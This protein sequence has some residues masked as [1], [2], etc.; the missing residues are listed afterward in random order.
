MQ[1][2][3]IWLKPQPK[4]IDENF[5]DFLLYLRNADNKSEALYTESLRL[6]QQRVDLLIDERQKEPIFR[7]SKDIDTLHFNARLC[8]AWLLCLPNEDY[9]KRK[10]VTIL[11]L[12][13]LLHLCLQSETEEDDQFITPLAQMATSLL[14]Y[15]LPD[16]PL[17][18][19]ND[20]TERNYIATLHILTQRQFTTQEEHFFEHKGTF[21]S[22]K[23][24][25]AISALGRRQF[26]LQNY[27]LRQS[28]LVEDCRIDVYTPREKNIREI[29][30]DNINAVEKTVEYLLDEISRTEVQ[31]YEVPRRHYNDNDEV[32][33][34]VVSITDNN[35]ILRTIDP[36]YVPVEG[37]LMVESNIRLY[38]T[39][40]PL[41]YWRSHLHVGDL[42]AVKV[43]V[44]GRCFS[45]TKVL[46]EYLEGGMQLGDR[47]EATTY[48]IEGKRDYLE[49]WTETGEA[50]FVHNL[51]NADLEKLWHNEGNAVIEITS[52]GYGIFRG[53]Y[54]GEIDFDAPLN[55]EPISR[56]EVRPRFAPEYLEWQTPQVD[57]ANPTADQSLPH[58]FL[59]EFC[60]ALHG[61]QCAQSDPLQRFRLLST[62]RL[63]SAIG[64]NDAELRYFTYFANYLKTLVLFARTDDNEGDVVK[65]VPVPEDLAD[66]DSIAYGDDILDI[67]H[68]FAKGYDETA[69][70]LDPY[71][72]SDNEEISMIAS[73]VQSY[74]RLHHILE[75]KTLIDI[76]RRILNSLSIAT[77]QQQR[78]LELESDKHDSFGYEDAMKEFKASYFFPPED[79]TDQQQGIYI[80]KGVCAMLNSNGGTLY[81]GV[82]DHGTP[83]GLGRDLARLEQFYKV[84]PTLDQ[85]MLHISHEGEK[86]FTEPVW[87]YVSLKPM[88][89][90]NVIKMEVE[91]YPY[92]IV[93]LKGVAYIR[94]NNAS[95]PILNPQTKQEI[96]R[97]RQKAL[98]D[99]DDK[100]IMLQEAI[101]R[102]RQVRLMGYKSSNSGTIRNRM[103]EPF[104]FDGTDYVICYE[105][106]TVKSFKI[107]RID[108][109]EITDMPWANRDEHRRNSID[110]FHIS[111]TTSIPITLHLTLPAKNALEDLYPRLKESITRLDENTWQ[112]TTQVFSLDPLRAFYLS[113]AKHIKI[114]EAPGLLDSV[115]DYIR[116]FIP[117][118]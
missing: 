46:E 78:T 45:M 5:D 16:K 71:I 61:L 11:M 98:H 107:A 81:L 96:R 21:Q 94:K 27:N 114:V 2:N 4:H 67:L 23:G 60:S 49:F 30:K 90:Y 72:D 66:E 93:E 115:H 108:K 42:L 62:L 76:K 109:V 77:R 87:R 12:N 103:V 38:Q 101:Q 26:H 88:A 105:S 24:N 106:G 33:A 68:C 39:V 74:N 28:N 112:L 56:D 44:S 9:L 3:Q 75:R 104:D 59:R 51:E 52:R 83:I 79:A 117:Q 32:A 57:Y 17:M 22:S 82:N 43:Q 35:I 7:H 15:R 70:T 47:V 113:Y 54:F 34:K 20:L 19:W 25:I 65:A 1:Q 8:G 58:S 13:N 102:E 10:L 18:D 29:D 36:A 73:L 99:C 50:V 86:Q 69:D 85:L 6:L 91:P 40:Y 89:E 80:F 100:Y 97:R 48:L 116:Q 55:F 14:A 84:A 31:H 92:D 110:A 53:L 111:G 41:E 63:L 118:A 95:A 64:D 37:K